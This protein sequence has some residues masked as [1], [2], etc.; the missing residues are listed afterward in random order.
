MGI[1]EEKLMELIKSDKSLNKHLEGAL[2]KRK[3]YIKDKL[4][5][6]II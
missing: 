6:L 4:I 2:I 3:I 1:S 5:N